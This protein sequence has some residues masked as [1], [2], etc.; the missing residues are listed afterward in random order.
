MIPDSFYRVALIDFLQVLSEPERI[1]QAIASYNSP[2]FFKT[3]MD[4]WPM[5][6]TWVKARV[7]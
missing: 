3:D 1:Y 2:L 4:L 6:V 7:R 5:V